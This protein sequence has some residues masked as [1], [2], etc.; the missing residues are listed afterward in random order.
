MNET[1]ATV[2]TVVAVAL[3]LSIPIVY[4]VLR[5]IRA[6]RALDLLHSE[7]MAAIERG[8]ELP[9]V[10]PEWVETGSS[11]KPRTALLPGLVWLFVGSAIVGARFINASESP[12]PL[13]IGLV[14]IGIGLAYLVYYF[15]EERKPT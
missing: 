4:F 6:R 2:S 10:A 14:P 8:M 7:R 3:A 5:H 12:P 13:F 11:A 15:L 1:L 9:P